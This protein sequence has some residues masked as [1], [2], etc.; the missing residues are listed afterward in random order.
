[1][2]ANTSWWTVPP[3]A[4]PGSEARAGDPVPSAPAPSRLRLDL[5]KRLF[6]PAPR[7]AAPRRA[8]VGAAPVPGV[9][10][11]LEGGWPCASARTLE[12]Q[13][14]SPRGETGGSIDLTGGPWKEVAPP[15]LEGAAG[16]GPLASDGALAP[17][18]IPLWRRLAYLLQPPAE[19]LLAHA[20]PLEW[21]G[22]F[23]PYQLEGI[24]ALISRETLLLA[25]DMGLGKTIQSA[26]ALRILALQGQV[27]SGLLIAPA[28]LLGQ[29]RRALRLW[30]PE[31][32]L[33][34]VRGPAEE[35][36]WQWTAPAHV[37]LTSYETLREDCTDSPHSPP[38]RRLWDVVVLDE[39]QRIKNRDSEASRKCKLLRRRRA[40]ALSGTPMEN[41]LEDLASVLEFVTPHR[42]GGQRAP[43][44]RASLLERLRTLQL[45]RRKADVLPQLPPKIVS[46]IALPLSGAQRES[47]E[48]AEREGIVAL[49]E[50]G[51]HVRI[52]NVLDLIVRLKQFCNF[53]P[54]T[55]ESAKLDDLRQRMHTLGL[56]GHRALV[57][58]QF[59]DG[60]YGARALAN[61]LTAFHPLLYTGELS[62][63]QREAIVQ[64]FR[65]DPS[66]RVLLLS[67]RAGGSGLNLQEASYVFHFDRWWNP[68]VERQAEDRSHRL[69]QSLPVH[70]YAY[71]CE[72]TIE[73]RIEAVLQRKQHLF[74]QFVD[75][76]TLDFRSVLTGEEI[77]GLFGLTP[78]A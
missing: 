5:P 68:A 40:W 45:R 78:P 61:H 28:S 6:V 48:R 33:S 3:E 7:D 16:E 26:A 77:Y 32:R 12:A 4:I 2:N 17:A 39:A 55:G 35:R 66:R 41:S 49:R 75:E 1:M 62:V 70:V 22:S 71:T 11:W 43:A 58:S 34:T 65:N 25:D 13:V 31:L 51:E 53:C 60:R 46:R 10:R 14:H 52:D 63:Q 76:V 59:V 9:A 73:E 27:E 67:L 30:A 64:Q 47:Y 29:W 8:A 57:F 19:L 36:A 56:Q 50:R 42:D 69:G 38:R 23:F 20:G 18:E 74:D 72:D 21:P 24:R 54:A 37:Y 15:P 44:S